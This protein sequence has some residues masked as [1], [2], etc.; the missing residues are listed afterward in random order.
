M[1]ND[2]LAITVGLGPGIIPSKIQMFFSSLWSK[3]I[4]EMALAQQR[5][6]LPP[7]YLE[8]QLCTPLVTS[9]LGECGGSGRGR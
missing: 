2:K 4:R 9:S 7:L 1:I 6:V 5:M 8:S 3:F